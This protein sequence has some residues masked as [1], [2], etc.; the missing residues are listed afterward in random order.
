MGITQ[1]QQP[2]LTGTATLDST[3]HP[4]DKVEQQA[5]PD[6]H[7]PSQPEQ[8]TSPKMPVFTNKPSVLIYG[9]PGSGKTT[10]AEQEVKRRLAA[11]H[12][13]IVCDPHATYPSSVT[14]GK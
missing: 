5:T 7:E 8:P 14:L 4:G 1:Q 11:G 12:R 2:A 13:V 10:F 3:T 6:A 9:A